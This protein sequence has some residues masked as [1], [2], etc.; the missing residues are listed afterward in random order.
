MIFDVSVII[1]CYNRLEYT[2]KCYNSLMMHCPAKTEVVFVDNLSTDG[3][4]E[5]LSSIKKDNVKVILNDKNYYP[6]GGNRI[7]LK[8]A[9]EAKAYLLCDNDGFFNSY[10]WYDVGMMFFND[11]PK[12][13]IVNLRESRWRLKNEEQENIHKDYKYYITNKVASFSLLRPDV[14]KILIRELKGKWIGHVIATLMCDNEYRSIRLKKGYIFD[15]SDNDLNNPEYRSQY[16]KLWKE[17]GRIKEFKR[18]VSIIN[19]ETKN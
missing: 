3:T 17:K 18:R 6:A 4:R 13:G 9:S 16:K 2:K 1:L 14:A 15:Q 11:F 8:N 19:N 5:W 7:G 10:L 12:I